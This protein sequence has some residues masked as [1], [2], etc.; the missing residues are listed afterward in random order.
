MVSLVLL[1]GGLG[2]GE[3][4]ARAVKGAVQ[5]DRL[6]PHS[7]AI[8]SSA[9]VGVLLILFFVNNHRPKVNKLEA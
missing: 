8:F 7:R 3:I 5:R 6:R 9:G 4:D 1:Q 2:G